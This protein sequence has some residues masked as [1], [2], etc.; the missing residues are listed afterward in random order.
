[1]QPVGGAESMLEQL[2]QHRR[3]SKRHQAVT[4]VAR[5]QD[6][7]VAAKLS[8]TSTIVRHCDDCRQMFGDGV[9]FRQALSPQRDAEPLEH[10]GQAGAAADGDDTGPVDGGRRELSDQNPLL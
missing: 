7:E 4:D 9:R 1:M 3:L 5:G 6:A 2:W 10:R 8:R